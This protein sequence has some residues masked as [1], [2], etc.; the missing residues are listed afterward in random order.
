[1]WSVGERNGQ[2]LSAEEAAEVDRLLDSEASIRSV[3]RQSGRGYRAVTRQL[4]EGTTAFRDAR[5]RIRKMKLRVLNEETRE[6]EVGHICDVIDKGIQPVYRITLADGKQLTATESHL[7]LT[8]EGWKTLH[9]AVGLEG[10]GKVAA[11]TRDCRLLV[12]GVAVYRDYEWMKTARDRGL[13]VSQMAES[14]DCSYPTIRSWLRRHDLKFTPEE[15]N[16]PRGHTPWNKSVKGYR[17]SRRWTEEQKDAIR[18]ARSGEKSNF[19]R[20]GI[21]SER[22]SVARWTTEQAPKVH[23]QYDYTCQVSTCRRR[24][25]RLHAHHIVP[26]WADPSRARDIGNLIT[27]CKTCHAKIHRTQETELA[28]ATEFAPY[29]GFAQ[30]AVGLPQR[31]GCK[32][33]AHAARVVAVEYVGLRQTYDLAVEGPWH[34]FVANGIVV[35]N[36]FNEESARY[37][38]LEGDFYV[39]APEDVRSQVG[40]PGAYTFD[41]VDPGTAEAVRADLS[42]HYEQAYRLYQELIDRGLA[43]EL[44]RCVLPMGTFTQFYWTVNA[45]S[46]MNF[47]SLRAADTAQLEIRRYAEAIETFFAELMPATYEAFIENG[48]VAP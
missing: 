12:N 23:H 29:L 25:G 9:E 32:L 16:F 36:S 17:L 37:H 45:R 3:I 5:W 6:F 10:A 47:L 24:G 13:S 44:A 8:D 35:H 27:V 40:K 14:A 48:R 42:A 18:A 1:M 22:A 30:E 11:T 39:P 46:L 41:P 31:K 21:S 19:W 33:T 34:N 4:T 28:F 43:K 15:R 38:Q 7:L 2:G 20:G 26:V